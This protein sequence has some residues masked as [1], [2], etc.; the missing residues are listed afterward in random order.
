MAKVTIQDIADELGLSRNTVSKAI[1]DT[2][3]LA[4]A[5]KER[6]LSKASEMG[7]KRFYLTQDRTTNTTESARPARGEIAILTTTFLADSHFAS[8]M[9]DRFQAELSA[10][11]YSISMHRIL[12]TDI[13]TKKLPSL[14]DISSGKIKGFICFEL[15]DY[16]YCRFLTEIGIPVLFVDTPVVG[17]HDALNADRLYMDNNIA[18]CA[19]VKFMKKQGCKNFGFI[20]EHLHC[21]SFYERFESFISAMRLFELEV[22]AEYCFLY[23]NKKV[24]NPG[25]IEYQEYIRDCLSSL[26]TLPDVFLCANDFVAMD[27]LAVLRSM[28]L[29]VPDDVMLCGFDDSPESKLLSPTL[30]TVHIHS[31]IM[32]YCAAELLLSRINAPDMDWRCVHTSTDIVY[33][34]STRSGAIPDV[35]EMV[36]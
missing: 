13:I 1:N 19:F 26:T 21:Q 5:T 36:A 11:G 6:I 8:T 33:R 30:T 18:I 24:K 14:L 15:F 10:A 35:N 22:R 34:E 25:S 20:G 17:L 28:K 31:Q 23:N 12:E 3:V 7:Y 9:L 4:D 29:D 16:G 2:G 32:G 27:V